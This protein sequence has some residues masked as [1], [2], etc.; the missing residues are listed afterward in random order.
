MNPA[1]T[2]E[3]TRTIRRLKTELGMTILLVEHDMRTVM[4]VC[5]QI[6]VLDFGRKIAEGSPQEISE[7]PQVIEAYLGAEDFAA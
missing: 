4:G 6:T 1:E 2:A 5:E 3:M 7:D